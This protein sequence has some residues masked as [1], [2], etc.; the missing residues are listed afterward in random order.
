MKSVTLHRQFED[1]TI[2]VEKSRC[3]RMKK[4]IIA[5]QNEEKKLF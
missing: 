1:V 5:T 4:V 3:V 2:I